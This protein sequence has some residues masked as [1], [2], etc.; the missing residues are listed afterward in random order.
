M[1]SKQ[2]NTC[3]KLLYHD[4]CSLSRL[5]LGFTRIL[6]EMDVTGEFLDSIILQDEN[7]IVLHQQTDLLRV[8]TVGS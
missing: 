3:R 7:G 8:L 4:K 5:K 1:L 6:I 2:G